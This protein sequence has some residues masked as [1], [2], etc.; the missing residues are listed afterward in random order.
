MVRLDIGPGRSRLTCGSHR[1]DADPI[2]PTPDRPARPRCHPDGRHDGA[3]KPPCSLMHVTS[4]YRRHQSGDRAASDPHCCTPLV[5]YGTRRGS[6]RSFRNT[7]TAPIRCRRRGRKVK[8]DI[9]KLNRVVVAFDD[10]PLGLFDGLQHMPDIIRTLLPAGAAAMVLNFE[11]MRQF[12]EMLMRSDYPRNRAL[13][14]GRT[15][16][17]LIEELHA[18]RAA[19]SSIRTLLEATPS[20]RGP[21]N[22]PSGASC[23]AW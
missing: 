7:G 11:P 23:S 6:R 18:A 2:T 21:I 15:P 20:R 5:W 17:R 12:G 4:P 14:G 16:Y 9:G 1:P 3:V 10:A 13:H 22:S 19:E 8:S